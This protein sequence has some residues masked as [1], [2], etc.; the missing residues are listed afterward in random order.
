MPRPQ[1]LA[2]GPA[3]ARRR[4]RA[5]VAV[6]AAIAG[7]G[8]AALAGLAIAKTFTV[9][10]VGHAKV[11]GVSKPEAIVANVHGVSLYTLSHDTIAHPGCTKANGCFA[12]WFPATVRSKRT[13]LTKPAGVRGTLRTFHRNG[14]FQLTL[15]NHPLYTF[16]L[17]SKKQG[18]ANGEGIPSFGGVW[19]VVKASSSSNPKTT[20]TTTSTGTPTM[21]YCLYPPC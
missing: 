8:L 3:P 18:V 15:N 1:F 19:H 11:S 5:I 9:E 4:R 21:P 13:K 2:S 6:T 14:F 12:F 20:T 7:F 10:V 16:K 17:D